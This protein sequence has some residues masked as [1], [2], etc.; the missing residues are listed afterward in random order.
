MVLITKGSQR[1]LGYM[2]NQ[3]TKTKELL[4]TTLCAFSSALDGDKLFLR[5]VICS[6]LRFI[7]NL[8]TLFYK[9]NKKLSRCVI[10]E[11]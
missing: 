10:I 7:D 8:K 11:S 1:I 2:R 9:R 5:Q 3:V 4:T 6:I